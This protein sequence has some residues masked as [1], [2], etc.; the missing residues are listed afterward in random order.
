MVK[1][2]VSYSMEMENMGAFSLSLCLFSSRPAKIAIAR[3]QRHSSHRHGKTK[4]NTMY[5]V[6]RVTIVQCRYLI[7][8]SNHITKS[9]WDVRI[10]RIVLKEN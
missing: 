9:V 4:I 8:F 7:L 6:D 10:L 1:D 5:D 3:T 2:Y